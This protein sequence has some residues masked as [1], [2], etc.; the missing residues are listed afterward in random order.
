MKPSAA[1][2]PR[3]RTAPVASKH[4]PA[5]WPSRHVIATFV[6]TNALR[7]LPTEPVDMSAIPD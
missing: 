4:Q 5:T 2:G 7:H 1:G 6:L 3:L